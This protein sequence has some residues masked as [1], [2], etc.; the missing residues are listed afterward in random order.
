MG[1]GFKRSTSSTSG[2]SQDAADYAAAQDQ[3]DLQSNRDDAG[4][5]GNRQAADGEYVDT[6]HPRGW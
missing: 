3:R 5:G 2:S 4:T 6:S 1:F